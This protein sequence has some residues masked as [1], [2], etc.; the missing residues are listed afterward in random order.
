[1]LASDDGVMAMTSRSY[2]KSSMDCWIICLA[3]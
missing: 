2:F 3:A 1:M